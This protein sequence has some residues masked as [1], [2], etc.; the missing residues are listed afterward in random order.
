[1]DF[2]LHITKQTEE[3]RCQET[4]SRGKTHDNRNCGIISK[5]DERIIFLPA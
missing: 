5:T 3:R 2:Y 1:M 4:I